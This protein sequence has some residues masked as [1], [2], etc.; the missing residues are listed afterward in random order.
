MGVVIPL[1][2]SIPSN[3]AVKRKVIN[4][5]QGMDVKVTNGASK[6]VFS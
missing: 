5:D 1:F 4:F 2:R 6:H 3:E